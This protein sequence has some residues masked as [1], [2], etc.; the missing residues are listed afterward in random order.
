MPFV[1]RDANNPL[2]N[3]KL[4]QGISSA[5]LEK[6]EQRLKEDII[7]EMNANFGLFLAHDESGFLI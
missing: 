3:L 2:Q 5:R 7:S 6:M 1:V 4:Y